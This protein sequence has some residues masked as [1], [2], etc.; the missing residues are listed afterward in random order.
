MD[1]LERI[2]ERRTADL[3]HAAMH[4]MLTGYPIARCF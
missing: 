4:D 1:E 3:T 2:V